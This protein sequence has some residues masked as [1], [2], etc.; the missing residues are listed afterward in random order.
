MKSLPILTQATHQPGPLEQ[1]LEKLW[2]VARARLFRWRNFG[3]SVRLRRMFQ[4]RPLRAEQL[5]LK[6]P[7]GQVPDCDACVE[8]CCTGKDAIVSLRLRDIAAL[9]D[10]GLQEHIA[11]DR[12]V[13][14]PRQQKKLGWARREADDSVFHQAFPVLRR[15]PTG[16]CTLLTEDRKCGAWP[17][18][19]LSCARYPYALDLQNRVVFYAKGCA[20]TQLL[21]VN[22]APFKVRELVLA[23]V[24]AYNA[25]VKDVVLVAM[26][27]DELRAMGLLRFLQTEHLP[28]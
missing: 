1:E 2:P 8:I 23:V 25:R 28:F 13:L 11:H 26:A 21:P 22:E 3:R 15:D 4:L 16:T 27:K 18:W 14:P 17:A 9:V 5:T 12:P 24:D 19:P 20:S 10:A 6:M 7:R